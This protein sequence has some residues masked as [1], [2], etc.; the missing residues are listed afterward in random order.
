MENITIGQINSFLVYLVGMGGVLFTVYKTITA[1]LKKGLKPIQDKI[2]A[3][4]INATKN[5]LVA[6]LDEIDKGKTIDGVN[7]ERFYEQLQHYQKDLQGNS[8]I[9]AE[10]ERLK[11]EG[12]L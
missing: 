1:G 5:F 9:M 4:D 6:R 12:K 2:D 8:Y 10:V 7:R 3:V 11:K